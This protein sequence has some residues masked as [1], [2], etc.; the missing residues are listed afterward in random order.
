MDATSVSGGKNVVITYRKHLDIFGQH[1]FLKV[2]SALI[3]GE[4]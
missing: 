2:I 1:F 4:C 3:G